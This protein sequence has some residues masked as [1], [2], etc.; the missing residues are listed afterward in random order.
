MFQRGRLGLNCTE[1]FWLVLYCTVLYCTVLYF[2]VHTVVYVTVHTVVN[3]TVPEA[4]KS[5]MRA[6]SNVPMREVRPEVYFTVL[7]CT[8]LYCTVLYCTVLYCTLLYCTVPEAK[9]P[10]MRAIRNVPTREVRA[11]VR[12]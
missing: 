6:T 2:T 5:V 4:I 11:E 1:L 12:R 9:K 8:V 7:Y 10:V 3:V